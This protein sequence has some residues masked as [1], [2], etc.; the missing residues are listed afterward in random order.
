M[1]TGSSSLQLTAEPGMR[2]RV[3]SLRLVGFHG[4]TPIGPP[5][6]G[7]TI[8]A[9]RARRP[10][11]RRPYMLHRGHRRPPGAEPQSSDR[12]RARRHPDSLIAISECL[13]LNTW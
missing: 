4:S 11:P 10:R 13:P 12:P 5:T 7:Y 2:G 1:S 3:M 9:V 6:V 8:S